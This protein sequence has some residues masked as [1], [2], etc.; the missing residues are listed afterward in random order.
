M[1]VFW[2][3]TPG[4]PCTYNERQEAKDTTREQMLRFAESKKVALKEAWCRFNG[5]KLLVRFAFQMCAIYMGYT[6]DT[7]K[8]EFVGFK[9][10]LTEE[11]KLNGARRSLS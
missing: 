3:Y 1:D 10:I 6:G 2:G 9:K 8:A 4:Q 7:I 5:E 11:E